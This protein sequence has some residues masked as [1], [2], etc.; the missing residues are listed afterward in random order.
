[1]SDE[2]IRYRDEFPILKNTTY[3]I[4]NSLGAMPRGVYDSMTSYCDVWATRGVRAWEENWWM[5]AR[6]V[7]DEIGVLMNAPPGSVSV[8][9][10][11]TVCQAVVASCFDFSGPRNKVVYSDMNFPSVMYFWEAQRSRGARVHM[12]KTDD[13]ISVPAERL[14]DAIDEQTLIV[15]ISHVVF[16]SSYIKD[17][18]AIIEKA[19]RVGAY[20]LLDTFQSLGNVP[21]DVQ[22]LNADFATGGVLKWLCGGAG[23]AYLYVRPDL[24]KKLE[25]KITGWFAHQNPFGFETGPIQ[26]G[27]PPYRFMQGTSN[28]PALYAARPGLKII[29]EI[30]VDRI[31]AKSKK[32][33]ARLIEQAGQRGWKVNCPLDPEK[34]GGTVA[35]DMPNS[36][37][38]SQELLRRDVIV[39]WRP[40]AGVRFSPHFYNTMEEIDRAMATVDEILSGMRV[41]K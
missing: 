12:V 37:E 40:R 17:A 9:Q 4:S 41:A 24:G 11:V 19:H 10:N 33:T 35:I 20:V 34:R 6:E 22:A 3:M 26:Y 21:V 28:I 15:P 29:R 7:G 14:I 13:G 31:R 1:M 36:Q 38:V 32:M 30:G 16:R 18:Q 39:D 2:L 27:G 23:T 5:L 8:H 25:P